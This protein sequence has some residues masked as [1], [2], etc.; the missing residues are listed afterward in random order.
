[1]EVECLESKEGVAGPQGLFFPLRIRK[2]IPT[3]CWVSKLIQSKSEG[4]DITFVMVHSLSQKYWPNGAFTLEVK[5]VI[6]ENLGGILGGTQ[7]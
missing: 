7:C 1:M 2:I 4:E 5:S 3:S 6:N